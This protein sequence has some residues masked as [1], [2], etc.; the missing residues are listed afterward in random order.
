MAAMLHDALGGHPADDHLDDGVDHHPQQ[1][2]ISHL[3]PG[4]LAGHHQVDELVLDLG[5][6]L[7]PGGLKR[8]QHVSHQVVLQPDVV[9]RPQVIAFGADDGL[10]R[11]ELALAVLGPEVDVLRPRPGDRLLVLQELAGRVTQPAVVLQQAR[12]LLAV[13]LNGR[14]SLLPVGDVVGRTLACPWRG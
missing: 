7:L 2:R 3:L 1:Q 11:R 5:A 4:G 9:D 12:D 8:L 14:A 13:L 6:Q 10:D